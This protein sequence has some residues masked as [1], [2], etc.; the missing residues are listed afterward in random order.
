M[1]KAA[2][3]RMSYAL[4]VELLAVFIALLR[5]MS[6]LQAFVI[7]L[8]GS[9]VLGFRGQSI[10]VVKPIRLQHNAVTIKTSYKLIFIRP[11]VTVVREDL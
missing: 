7:A 2:N 9:Y 6:T 4:P 10:F 11:P 1:Q 5:C 3:L 8:T